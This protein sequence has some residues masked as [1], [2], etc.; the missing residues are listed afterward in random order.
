MSNLDS[1]LSKKDTS[2]TTTIIYENVTYEDYIISLK[3]L[4]ENMVVGMEITIN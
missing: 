2:S 4:G 3:S 1:K